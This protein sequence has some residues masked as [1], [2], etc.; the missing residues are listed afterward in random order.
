MTL[1]LGTKKII[2]HCQRP[3]C[4]ANEMDETMIKN[5]NMAVRDSDE[6]YILGDLSLNSKHGEKCLRRLRGKKYLITGNH[7]K[8]TPEIRSLCEWVGPYKEVY[9]DDKKIILFHYP[10]VE[11]NGYNHGTLHFYG[12][13]HNSKDILAYRVMKDVPNAYNVGADVLGFTP[14]TLNEIITMKENR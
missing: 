1:I 12:H 4:D 8:I 5:W 14:R 6:V 7:D 9:D 2:E 3:F 10:I 11:W 13:I